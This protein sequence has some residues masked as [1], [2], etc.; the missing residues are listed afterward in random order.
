MKDRAERVRLRAPLRLA[1]AVAVAILLAYGL[2]VAAI[3]V[4]LS[5]SVER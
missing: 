5:T 4:L 2:Y 1:R 3:N